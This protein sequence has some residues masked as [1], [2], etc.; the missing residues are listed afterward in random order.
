MSEVTHAKLTYPSGEVLYLDS[1]HNVGQRERVYA[2]LMMARCPEMVPASCRV[3]VQYNGWAN[4]ILVKGALEKEGILFTR[5]HVRLD[6]SDSLEALQA[7]GC[8]YAE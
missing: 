6:R 7:L 5:L 4:T 8:T 2:A 1:A 3:E